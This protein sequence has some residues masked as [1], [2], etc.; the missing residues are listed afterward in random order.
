MRCIGPSSRSSVLWEEGTVTPRAAGSE[1]QRSVVLERGWME[2]DAAAGATHRLVRDYVRPVGDAVMAYLDACE[3]GWLLWSAVGVAVVHGRTRLSSRGVWASVDE[4]RV[5]SSARTLASSCWNPWIAATRCRVRSLGLRLRSRSSSAKMTSCRRSRRCRSRASRK[6]SP[7]VRPRRGV[8]VRVAAALDSAPCRIPA[9]LSGELAPRPQQPEPVA[10]NVGRSLRLRVLIGCV[11]RREL[12]HLAC[13]GEH[14]GQRPAI[15][16]P[17]ESGG[18]PV[19][20]GGSP[21]QA[22]AVGEVARSALTA[23]GGPPAG[24]ELSSC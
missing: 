9:G 5:R 7:S 3:R 22:G 17:N 4:W 19:E 13:G 12:R 21:E 1:E 10:T 23:L 18:A 15:F 6:L 20:C 2:R 24:N 8:S 11:Y 16:K 14:H